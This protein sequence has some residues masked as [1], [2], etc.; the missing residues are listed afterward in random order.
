MKQVQFAI[1]KLLAI[2][3]LIG[4][5][6]CGGKAGAQSG[7]GKPNPAT[8]FAYDLTADGKGILIKSYTGA[9]GK[10]VIPEKIEGLPV[11]E[12]GEG[13][14]NGETTTFSMPSWGSKPA[15]VDIGSKSNEK[16]GITAIII[17]NTVRKIGYNAFAH[18]A[19]TSLYIPDSVT[20][21]VHAGLFS[22][23]NIIYGCKQLVEVR[24]SDNLERIPGLASGFSKSPPVRKINLPKNLKQIGE[25]AFA[26]SELTELIIPETLTVIE[27]VECDN[28]WGDR[29]DKWVKDKDPNAFVDCSK[30][31]LAT[32]QKLKDLGYTGKF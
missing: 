22:S 31:P 32:R 24:L 3:L 11:L 7:G 25:L 13:A 6:A 10:V 9:P 27:F 5:I 12:I 26:F 8:D 1:V 19:I 16:A 4:L 14:F 20:E 2:G 29:D 21:L 30:L 18:T 23:S 15:D 17:P 28:G